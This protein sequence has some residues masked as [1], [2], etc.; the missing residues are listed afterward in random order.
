MR[1]QLTNIKLV[2]KQ[3]SFET[4][5]LD[6]VSYQF[7]GEFARLANFPSEEDRGEE[8]ILKGVLTILRSKK[9]VTLSNVGFSYFGGD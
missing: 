2:D 5:E 6:G 7:S 1:Y 8:I 9:V 3:F 4:T